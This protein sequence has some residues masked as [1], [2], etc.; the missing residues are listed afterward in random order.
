MMAW[1]G[2]RRQLCATRR[3][4]ASSL[5]S[6]ALLVLSIRPSWRKDRQWAKGEGQM[7]GLS[8][9]RTQGTK[10]QRDAETWR[11]RL[12]EQLMLAMAEFAGRQ[13]ISPF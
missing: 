2:K 11:V 9:V 6:R 8:A 5:D 13:L 3:G 1:G 4:R 10:M 7:S 12:N